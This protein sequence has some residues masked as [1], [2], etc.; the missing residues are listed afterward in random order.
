MKISAIC[1]KCGDI[2]DADYGMYWRKID[3][4]DTHGT[5]PRRVVT[6]HC[7]ACGTYDRS[8]HCQ[9]DLVDAKLLNMLVL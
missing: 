4:I 7:R 5:Q 8:P 1:H 3:A 9:P 6:V 2:A